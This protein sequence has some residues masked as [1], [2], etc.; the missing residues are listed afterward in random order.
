M[1][2]EIHADGVEEILVEFILLN[3]SGN[4]LLKIGSEC[5]IYPRRYSLL[6]ESSDCGH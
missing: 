2:Y 3:E 5:R 1:I 4:K 6:T